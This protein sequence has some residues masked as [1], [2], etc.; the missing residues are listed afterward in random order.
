M[1]RALVLTALLGAVPVRAVA[2]T[3][4]PLTLDDAMTR[5]LAASHRLAEAVA[6]GQAAEAVANERRAATA[7]QVSGQAGY[8]RTNHVDAFGILSPSN[9]LKIIYPDVPDNYRARLDLQWPIYTGGRLDALERAA[10]AEAS[11]SADDLAAA[12]ADLR[13]EITRAYWA[14]ATAVESLRV[15]EESVTRVDAHLQDVRNQLSAGLVPPND[16]SSVEAQESRQR[17][18][19]VQARTTRDV[20]DAE[21]GRLV[22]ADLDAAIQPVSP[23][24]LPPLDADRQTPLSAL[25]EQARAGRSERVALTKRV[26]AAEERSLAAAAGMKPT[27]GIAGRLRLRA[28]EPANLSARSS[29]APFMGRRHQRQLAALRR[30]PYP[31]RDDG[32]RG[33]KARVRGAARGVRCDVGRRSAP[34]VERAAIESGRNRRGRRFRA[35]RDRGAQGR[36]RSVCGRC[37]HQHGRARCAGGAP[38]GRARSHASHR[39]RAARGSAPEP[40][41][42]ALSLCRWSVASE[43]RETIYERD[44]R[45][46]SH[47]QV[48]R[49]RGGR[50]PHIRRPQRERSSASSARTAPASRRRSACSAGC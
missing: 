27:I 26:A 33:H 41:A 46:R 24:D 19:S 9:Q 13:L 23:L 39:Q 10:L 12:R 31:R 18:L 2:Q 1:K 4:V 11:A 38:A 43:G 16:V 15:V 14:L 5:G 32:G 36:R 35:Q 6:R 7:P 8:T 37:R 29:L 48:R 22:G 45:H 44:H 49:F 47:P 50:S 20:A 34:A 21:L 30:R 3:T 17:M 25:V 28:A 42:G 40:G